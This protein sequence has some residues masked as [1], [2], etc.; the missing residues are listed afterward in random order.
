MFAVAFGGALKVEGQEARG[1]SLLFGDLLFGAELVIAVAAEADRLVRMGFVDG[2]GLFEGERGEP[3]VE[4]S[5]GHQAQAL[6]NVLI[7]PAPPASGYRRCGSR[8]DW[9]WRQ[10][11]IRAAA[12]GEVM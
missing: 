3:G 12:S 8:P 11:P 5:L 10:M 2:P 1:A 6:K 4:A 9:A 7:G